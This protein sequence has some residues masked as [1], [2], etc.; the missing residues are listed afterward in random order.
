MIALTSYM[1]DYA[2]DIERYANPPNEELQQI[3]WLGIII[4]FIMFLM[5][6]K[7]S[8]PDSY[9]KITSIMWGVVGVILLGWLYNQWKNK[10]KE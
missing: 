3:V 4:G 6:L 5:I 2:G 10:D 9:E 8:N 7:R 1:P